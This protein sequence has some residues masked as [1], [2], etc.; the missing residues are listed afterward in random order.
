MRNAFSAISEQQ[1]RDALP[2]LP[3]AAKPTIEELM[4]GQVRTLKSGEFDFVAAV[5]GPD[6]D[7]RFNAVAAMSFDDPSALEKEFRKWMETA[8]P[9][10]SVGTFKWNADKAGDVNIHTFEFT[11]STAAAINKPFGDKCTLAFAFAPKAIFLALGSDSI[12]TLKEAMKVKPAESPALD[13]FVNPAKLAKLVQAAGGD[14]LVIERAIGKEDKRISAA[15][16][17]VTSGKDLKVRFAMNLKVLARPFFFG[18][19]S[20]EKR[21]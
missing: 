15:S 18:R 20:A 12:A 5:R 13:I 11:G 1:Q 19:E 2:G 4:K 9:L 10:Q 16:L 8:S 17:R 3:E 14:P 21:D 7:G 6:K